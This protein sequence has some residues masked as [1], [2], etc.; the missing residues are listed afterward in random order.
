MTPEQLEREQ[1]LLAHTDELKALMSSVP[2][3]VIDGGATRVVAWKTA[4]TRAQKTLARGTK[5]PSKLREHLLELQCCIGSNAAE[6]AK[7]AYGA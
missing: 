7:V 5:D 4:M 1:R 6:L 3:A 2:R